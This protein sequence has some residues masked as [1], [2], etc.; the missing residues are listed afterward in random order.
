MRRA[1][2]YAMKERRG[3]N[4]LLQSVESCMSRMYDCKHLHRL[5]QHNVMSFD[6]AV[7]SVPTLVPYK[8]CDAGITSLSSTFC[9]ANG[10]VLQPQTQFQTNAGLTC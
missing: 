5:E 1:G 3:R 7:R 2:K 8:E 9:S 10:T 4:N 6:D